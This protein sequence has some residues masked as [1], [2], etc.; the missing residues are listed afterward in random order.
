MPETITTGWDLGGAHLKVAQVDGAGR[1]RLARQLPCT[2]WRGMEHLT[3]AL[4]TART[5]LLPSPRHGVTMTG[6]LTDL[7]DDRAD[8]VYRLVEAFEAKAEEFAE[9]RLVAA[10]RLELGQ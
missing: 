8:G 9:R 4:A 10:Q 5:E 3:E 7:F 2:L 6:E 1:L